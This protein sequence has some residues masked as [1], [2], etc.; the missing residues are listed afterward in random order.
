M[1]GGGGGGGMGGAWLVREFG[2]GVCCAV[3]FGFEAFFLFFL[4]P[5]LCCFV[6]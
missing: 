6:L 2:F 4:D 1:G 5:R 3:G